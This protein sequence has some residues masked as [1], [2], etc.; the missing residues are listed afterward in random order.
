MNTLGDRRVF[1]MSTNKLKQI[2]KKLRQSFMLVVAP[3]YRKEDGRIKMVI[4]REW[5]CFERKG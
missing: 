2:E 1:S 5:R 3:M 4:M